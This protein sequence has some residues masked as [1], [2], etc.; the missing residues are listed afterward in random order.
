[1]DS[2]NISSALKLLEEAIND[3]KI[4]D[5]KSNTIDADTIIKLF[6]QKKDLSKKPIQLNQLNQ[7][8]SETTKSHELINTAE[9]TED[10]ENTESSLS[11]H[12]SKSYDTDQITFT[13]GAVPSEYFTPRSDT[14]SR[15]F[16]NLACTR[17]ETINDTDTD[18]I[19]NFK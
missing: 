16:Y 9:D 2:D 15:S 14:S 6:K 10:T 8:L 7:I 13:H 12:Y 4:L 18:E 11:S 1:M 3:P 19:I 5:I 17:T